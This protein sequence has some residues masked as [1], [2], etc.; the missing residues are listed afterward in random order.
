MFFFLCRRRFRRTISTEIHVYL[1]IA[2]SGA[3]RGVTDDA[4]ERESDCTKRLVRL[5]RYV[6]VN[7]GR[8][9]GRIALQWCYRGLEER[10]RGATVTRSEIRA[11]VQSHQDQK[12]RTTAHASHYCESRVVSKL[13]RQVRR[14]VGTGGFRREKKGERKIR[15][16]R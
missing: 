8:R 3:V 7:G 13:L 12:V 15:C 4:G 11:R 10:P 5:L 1:E 9:A 2:K 14:V 16:S 6:T